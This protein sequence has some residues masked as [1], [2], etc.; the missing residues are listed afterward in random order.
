[1]PVF[2]FMDYKIQGQSFD[3]VIVDLTAACSLQSVYVMLLHATSL[4]GLAVLCWFPGD[5]LYQ[6]LSEEVRNEFHQFSVIA[7]DTMICFCQIHST[8]PPSMT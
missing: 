2:A 8:Q 4:A 7:S 3:S 6:R 1:M 5:K